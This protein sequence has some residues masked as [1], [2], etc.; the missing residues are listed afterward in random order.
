M[1]R[2]ITRAA[3]RLI[4]IERLLEDRA[5]LDR[6]GRPLTLKK[7]DD[8]DPSRL[9]PTLRRIL[10][11]LPPD[12]VELCD[13]PVGADDMLL[14]RT[15]SL[16]MLGLSTASD[17]EGNLWVTVVVGQIAG[18][19]DDFA[20]ASLPESINRLNRQ[21]P[22]LVWHE[23]DGM[24]AAVSAAAVRL[25][26][27][28]TPWCALVGR[29]FLTAQSVF[30][31]TVGPDEEGVLHPSVNYARA[32]EIV[33]NAPE[34]RFTAADIEEGLYR[35]REFV[36]ERLRSVLS[37]AEYEDE[38]Y[39]AV[40]FRQGPRTERI[41]VRVFTLE[42]DAGSDWSFPGIHITAPM[43]EEMTEH[44]AIAWC[45][46][47]NREGADERAARAER[48]EQ[49]T[50]WLLGNWSWDYRENGRS[51]VLYHGY[52]PNGLKGIVDLGEVLD[53]VV[54]EV[55]VSW[56]K[57]RLRSEFTETIKTGGLDEP[58]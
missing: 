11:T 21:F 49:T 17:P 19:V 50:P 20:D 12:I 34:N 1:D 3:L 47:L 40:P 44:E 55:W 22:G 46:E 13:E 24:I 56:D 42:E 2:E 15:E 30:F 48:W 39:L 51:G 36:P 23:L 6:L 43:P 58:L 10:D 18:S 32:T 7:T 38:F 35:Y 54:R 14:V 53:G 45:A 4:A 57:R 26:H 8:A 28:S 27:V 52:I 31:S 33:S 5:A 9:L 29:L 25:D 37:L 41:T 16:G